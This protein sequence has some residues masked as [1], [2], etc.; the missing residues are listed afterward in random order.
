M[1]IEYKLHPIAELFPAMT[2]DEF[3]G[4]KADIKANGQRDS[5]TVWMGQLI[6]GRHR[7]RACN[8]LGIEP[9]VGEL[10]EETDPVTWAISL[11]LHRRHLSTAQRAE[12][13]ARLATLK[14]GQVGMRLHPGR[15]S[16]WKGVEI[17]KVE[18]PTGK[19]MATGGAIPARTLVS[20]AISLF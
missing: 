1:T 8:E 14:R 6:D 11:N 5:I 19:E 10:M 12:I 16:V 17:A 13:A 18:M 20:I 9:I 2:E 15:K 3:E 7:L 4:L